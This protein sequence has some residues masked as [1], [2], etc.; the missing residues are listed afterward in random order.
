M[1]AR[2]RVFPRVHS[3][4]IGSALRRII[5]TAVGSLGTLLG[6]CTTDSPVR[7]GWTV[8]ADT[9][10]AGIIRVTNTPPSS[11]IEPTW[12]IEPDVRI[13][14][15]QGDGP[16]VFSEIKSIAPLLDG[17]IAVLDA[18]AQE[19]R[20]FD[21]DGE[22]LRTLGRPGAGPGEFGR[23]DGL[24]VGP[25][26]LILVRDPA[27]S[28]L[29]FFNPDDGLVAE[30]RAEIF[31][32]GPRWEATNDAE[33]TVYEWTT[34]IHQGRAWS[35]I[36][37]YDAAGDRVRTVPIEPDESI[38]VGAYILRFRSGS[39]GASLRMTSRGRY[40]LMSPVGGIAPQD[41]ARRSQ[42]SYIS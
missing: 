13:G 23:A 7:G 15:L 40:E 29:S 12:V 31:V 2:S 20:I 41:I 39:A 6:G 34:D 42:V 8:T 5:V 33:G 26:G 30:Q 10:P 37:V 28:R 27:N 22:Y 21:K 35:V 25:D 32:S 16:E 19:I 9:S 38:P 36:N 14:A 24:L 1:P 3:S 17:R 4:R 18:H 11:G